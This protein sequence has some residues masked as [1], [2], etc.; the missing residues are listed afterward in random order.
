MLSF[1][2]VNTHSPCHIVLFLIPHFPLLS[3][4]QVLCQPHQCCIMLF[5]QHQI[6]WMML[7]P[8]LHF[9]QV[10]LLPLIIL[11]LWIL[12]TFPLIIPL[13]LT[14]HPPCLHLQPL[15]QSLLL[16]NSFPLH[17]FILCVH[18]PWTRYLKQNK[19]SSS[20]NISFPCPLSLLG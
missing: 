2:R 4:N 10:T 18:S 20:P 7:M 19:Y 15:S 14:P 11:L 9:P 12:Q 6:L 3:F 16:I 8:L 17:D 5:V 13:F 1:M